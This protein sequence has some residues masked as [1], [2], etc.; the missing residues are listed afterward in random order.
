MPDAAQYSVA[1]KLVGL[2]RIDWKYADLYLREAATNIERLCTREQFH[3]MRGAHNRVKRLPAELERAIQLDDWPK[4]ERLASESSDLRGRVERNSHVLSLAKTIYGKKALEANPTV[5]ALSGAVSHPQTV[6]DRE[7]SLLSSDLRSLAN[8]DGSPRAF[9]QRRAEELD[10]MVV[11]LPEESAPN[12]DPAELRKVALAAVARSDF[13]TIMRIA[14]SAARSRRDRQGRIRAP[15]PTASRVE[16]LTETL[17][18]DVIECATTFG[19]EPAELELNPTFNSYLSC[20]CA[21]RA[22][23]PSSPDTGEQPTHDACTCGHTCP[24]EIGERLKSTLD[25]LMLHPSLTSAGTRYLPW[26]GR[27]FVL[28]ETF[29]EDEPNAPSPLLEALSL[30]RRL[31]LARL[32]IEDALLSKGPAVCEEMGLDPTAFRIVCIPFDAYKRLAVRF[33]W[34]TQRLWTHFDGY[35]LTRERRLLAIV[36]G[37][38]HYGGADD[39]SAVGRAYDSDHITTRFAV[40]RRDRFET[41]AARA[42]R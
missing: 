2:S 12:I 28:V 17:P 22:V 25:S 35:H 4:A 9:Y 18:T 33:G 26:F 39:L 36:G 24:S 8:L 40:V 38:I 15:I 42:D 37:D 13:A 32:E 27:E 41:R 10:R 5:L 16:R 1:E 3:A 19:L 29:P 6:L 11:D 21:D 23:L 14:Q 34:G 20:C 30:S 31:G 7:I